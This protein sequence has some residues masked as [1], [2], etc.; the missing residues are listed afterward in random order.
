MFD[1]R[2]W[3][4]RCDRRCSCVTERAGDVRIALPSGPIERGPA[5]FVAGAN[6]RAFFDQQPNDR[7]IGMGRR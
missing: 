3:R 5:R 6:V 2:R 4:E 1:G 7:G